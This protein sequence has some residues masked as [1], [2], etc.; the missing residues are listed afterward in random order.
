MKICGVEI[1]G[2]EAVVCLLN[3]QDGLFTLPEC[4]V[5]KVEFNKRNST[6]DL[7]YFQATFK[8]LMSD[9]S[10][11]QVVIKERPLKGKFAGG[12]LGF[13]MEAAI[14][15]IDGL[16]VDTMSPQVFKEAIKRNPI[17]VSFSETGLKVFQEAA[18]NVAFA[19]HMNLQYPPPP[20]SSELL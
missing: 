17:T 9:Y 7:R 12:A 5:R 3:Y 4:R 16:E 15:C 8:K 1:K 18:F 6:G 13:K 10:V 14:Q 2:S 11:E 19:K 20:P